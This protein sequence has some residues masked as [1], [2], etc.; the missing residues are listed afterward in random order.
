MITQSTDAQA[1]KH[2]LG[3]VTLVGNM[4]SG[5]HENQICYHTAGIENITNDNK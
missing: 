2:H 5:M 4:H 1:K 3:P